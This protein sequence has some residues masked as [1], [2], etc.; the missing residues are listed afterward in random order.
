MGDAQTVLMDMRPAPEWA[1][2]IDDPDQFRLDVS[3]TYKCS[4][5]G[6]GTVAGVEGSITI[7]PQSYDAA[8]NT[9][10]FDL[11]V[12]P[13]GPHHGVV[14]LN[15]LNTKRTPSSATNTGF[16]NFRAIRPGYDPNTTQLFN[17]EFLNAIK[18]AEFSVLRMLGPLRSND[19]N[20]VFYPTRVEW[21]QRRTMNAATWENDNTGMENAI[22]WEVIVDVANISKMDLW[23]N[24]P[25][26]ASDNYVQQLAAF[27][28]NR[29]NPDRTL[30]VEY[31]NE[32]WNW[33][34]PQSWWND[35]K[36]KAEG[37]NHVKGYS[38]RTVELAQIFRSVY[39]PSSL[40]DKVRVINAWQIGW[41]P[42]DGM[43]EEQMQYINSTF[44]PP[45]G[46]HLWLGRCSLL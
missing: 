27:I 1:G 32:V 28:K 31:S 19:N 24:V 34:F 43:Y 20:G 16:T 22:P 41:N 3:G 23:I 4:F 35:A 29:L 6:Q 5:T 11:T 18:G 25:I 39:G 10:R 44:G 36:A 12:G 14:I 15:F 17:T 46:F 7:G 38:K 2:S 37:L 40:N 30:Y 13:P 8:T 33:G 9:T 45:K 26:A 42:P 21:S